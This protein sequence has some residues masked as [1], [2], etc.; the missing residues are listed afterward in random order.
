M[1]I[2]EEAHTNLRNQL[3]LTECYGFI[4]VYILIVFLLANF[5]LR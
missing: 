3:I 5:S 4:V 2:F 1:T